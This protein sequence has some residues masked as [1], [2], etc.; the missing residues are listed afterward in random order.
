MKLTKCDETIDTWEIPDPPEVKVDVDCGKDYE[1]SSEQVAIRWEAAETPNPE[2]K[3]KDVEYW[4][5]VQWR[6]RWGN[7]RGAAPRTQEHEIT[8]PRSV[9]GP[10]QEIRIRVLVTSGIA[11]G[12]A[13]WSG[14]CGEIPQPG[15]PDAPVV[16]VV[17]VAGDETRVE[18]QHNLRAAVVGRQSG[19]TGMI[20][21]HDS[22]GGEVARGRSLDL[23]SLPIGQTTVSATL[24]GG[25]QR[26][27]T[28]Q[29][30]VERTSDDRFYLLQGDQHPEAPCG[31]PDEPDDGGHEHPGDNEDGIQKHSR[32][33]H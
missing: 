13:E 9:F 7:W 14:P 33:E 26:V 15:T 27:S 21:W 28:S 18:L 19:A 12:V 20:R 11:T 24:I 2:R 30:L 4:A 6:D 8:I 1:G 22:N 5:L 3:G 29:W 31:P 25:S 17:G 32:K 10:D 16:V 23:R